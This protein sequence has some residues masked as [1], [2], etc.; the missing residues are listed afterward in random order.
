MGLPDASDS[1]LA[2][3]TRWV[4]ED[5]GFADGRIEPASADASFR[6][7]FR[8]TRGAD[9]YIVMDAPPDKEDVAPFVSVARALA[10]I[11]LNVPIV[12][13]S[14]VSQGFLLLS[15]LGSRLYLDELEALDEL[16]EQDAIDR[17]Y[18]QAL[19]ALVTMQTAGSA[20]ARELPTYDRALLLREMELFPQWFLGRHIGLA[21]GDGERRMLDRLFDALAQA[22]LSQPAAFVH[23][24]YHSRNLLLATDNGPGILDFQDAVFG[25][26]TY[27]AVSL[28][29]DCYITWPADRV[30]GWVLAYRERLMLAGV[31]VGAD[32]AAFL[33]W[34][35]LMGLQRH[36]KVLGIFA[37]LYYR[38][39][40]RGYL[41]DLPRVLDYTRAVASA[42]PETAEFAVF[43]AQRIEPAF[44]AAQARVGA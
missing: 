41:K 14:D 13:A 10:G 40:K 7:Y 4:V 22:A 18:A 24:D 42:Y 26:I 44:V 28:L 8:V 27:D 15:D 38:D 36:I 3:L 23:R 9:T 32:A 11:S 30:R 19:Q 39:G 1:R 29:K 12:L 20:A 21:V 17:L 25:P 31:A 43:L 34:F 16:E 2:A 37:R 5:L 33:R 35:D 6:R